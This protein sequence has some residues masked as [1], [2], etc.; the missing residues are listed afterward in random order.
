[1]GRP[2]LWVIA[3][4]LLASLLV[5]LPTIVK[6]PVGD[7]VS[8]PKHHLVQAPE[9]KVWVNARSGLYRCPGASGYGKTQPGVYMNQGQAVQKGYRPLLHEPCK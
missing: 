3:A 5:F 8:F 2:S 4:L 1:M 9:I 6:L 7:L